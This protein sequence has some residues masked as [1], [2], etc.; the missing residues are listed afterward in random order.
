MSRLGV[1]HGVGHF[2]GAVSG[3]ALIPDAE[4]AML[5][6][7][8]RNDTRGKRRTLGL[9]TEGHRLV[10]LDRPGQRKQPRVPEL[11]HELRLRRQ[12]KESRSN[13]PDRY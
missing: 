8:N 5:H 12:L 3:R 13:R 11:Q 4:T 7:M 6:R 2:T 1:A 10:V 9:D